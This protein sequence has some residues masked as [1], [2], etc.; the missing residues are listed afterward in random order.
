MDFS[1]ASLTSFFLFIINLFSYC[2]TPVPNQLVKEQYKKQ[3][4]ICIYDHYSFELCC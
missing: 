3:T 1:I 4:F 2:G